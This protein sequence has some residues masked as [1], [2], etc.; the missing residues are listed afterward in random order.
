M[1]LSAPRRI[2]PGARKV[3][4]YASWAV[5][6][7]AVLLITRSQWALIPVS[8]RAGRCSALTARWGRTPEMFRYE[9]GSGFIIVFLVRLD[10]EM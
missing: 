9:V 6:V 2:G 10:S 1:G 4:V 7:P 5:A 3:Y 8:E